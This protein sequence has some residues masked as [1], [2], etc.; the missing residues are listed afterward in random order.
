M[1]GKSGTTNKVTSGY[2][3]SNGLSRQKFKRTDGANAVWRDGLADQ[4][5]NHQATKAQEGSLLHGL[6][7]LCTEGARAAC[8]AT[9]TLMAL[10]H[11]RSTRDRP[12]IVKI[13]T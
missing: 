6:W 7:G 8:A 10:L 4:W 3:M 9:R 1:E 2:Q 5:A 12:E 11:P 13:N